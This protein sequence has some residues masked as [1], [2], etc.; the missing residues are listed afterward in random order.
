MASVGSQL[1][2]TVLQLTLAATLGMVLVERVTAQ[3]RQLTPIY[4]QEKL[5]Y[6]PYQANP[7]NKLLQHVAKVQLLLSRDGATDW[8]VLQEAQPNVQ[9]FSYH[10]P[11][12]GE[13][14]LTLRHLDRLGRASTNAVLSPQLRIVVDTAKPELHLDADVDLSGAIILSY[15]ASDANLDPASL[16]LQVRAGKDEWTQVATEKPDVAQTDKLVGR[17]QWQAPP[18]A[19]TVE[20]RASIADR[21][22]HR[23]ETG[24]EVTMTGPTFTKVLPSPSPTERSSFATPLLESATKNPFLQ[25]AQPTPQ[26]WPA[27]NQL[28]RVANGLSQNDQ[29]ASTFSAMPPPI[30]NP[31]TSTDREKITGRTPAQLVGDGFAD[32]NVSQDEAPESLSMTPLN[33]NNEPL[34][35]S[36][37]VSSSIA[38]EQEGWKSSAASATTEIR[39]V[40]SRTFDVEYELESVGPW[41]VSKV[42]LW[43]T[44]DGGQTWQSYGADPDNR[45]PLRVTVPGSGIYGFRILVHGAGGAAARS[46]QSGEEAELVVAVD[47]LP[48]TV[49]L[50]E[51]VLGQDE[52]ANHLYIRW[53]ATDTNLQPRP[54]A[55]FYSSQPGGPWSTIA[56]GLENTGT[57]SWQIERHVPARFYLRIEAL[58]SAGN[59]ATSQSPSPITLPRPQPTGK[60]RNVRPVVKRS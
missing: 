21:A 24:K 39:A 60:L 18:G 5:F 3:A 34:P 43:G 41:G 28:P 52:F 14:W 44:H 40:N 50:S 9:G 20:V 36:C 10:A 57:Y 31:Y 42:E 56:A 25:A 6:V 46:P 55:L 22:G 15:K 11:D 26:S 27:S 7:R 17:G 35:E 4:W 32:R 59:V 30:H 47:L 12:D 51:A 58:D 53:M 33:T 37:G 54:I 45:S 13:Y 29:G 1:L 2:Q 48:P 49:K 23:T 16:L 38:A 19:S 8:R